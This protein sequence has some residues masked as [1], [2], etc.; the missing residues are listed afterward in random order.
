MVRQ[1]L[2]EPNMYSP[3]DTAITLDI[4]TR[5]MRT[6]ADAKTCMQMFAAALFLTV[7]N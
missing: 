4:Y 3:H 7:K 6:L 1:L 5:D 2:A